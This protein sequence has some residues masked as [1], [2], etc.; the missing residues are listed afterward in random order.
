MEPVYCSLLIMRGHVVTS[1]S[2]EQNRTELSRRR[3]LRRTGTAVL[4]GA[5][6]LAGA[7]GS[8]SAAGF[9]PQTPS[10]WKKNWHHKL[11]TPLIIPPAKELSK[12]RIR[13]FLDPAPVWNMGAEVG[14][15]YVATYLNLWLRPDPDPRCANKAVPVDGIGTV[16]WEHVKNA[17]QAWLRG[18]DWDGSGY[19]SHFQWEHET[20]VTVEGATGTADGATLAKALE[21]FNAQRFDALE[22]DAY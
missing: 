21:G 17:A 20:E 5:G 22:Y 10:Y 16:E 1:M 18:I 13:R 19:F 14:R 8:V 12:E 15:E 9:P 3:L 6:T 7:S 11:G 2:E 4:V